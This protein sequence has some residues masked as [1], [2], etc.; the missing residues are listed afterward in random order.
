MAAPRQARDTAA[1]CD[2]RDLSFAVTTMHPVESSS[3]ES[4]GHD[5]AHLHV[6]FK[7][8]HTYQ[9]HDVP[10]ETFE[11]ARTAESIGRFINAH[12]KGKH[13]STKLEAK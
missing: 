5:G 11:A 6:K 2:P 13:P 3:V 10:P 7:N 8:G 1:A 9:F 12:V 4:I